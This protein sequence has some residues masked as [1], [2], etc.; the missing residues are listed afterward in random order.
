MATKQLRLSD[1]G[2]IKKRIGDFIG[3]K[4]NIVLIDNT[5]VLGEL[6]GMNGIDILLVNMRNKKNSYPLSKIAEVYIDIKV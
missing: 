1:P 3:K 6:K 2:Q 4:I 5:A